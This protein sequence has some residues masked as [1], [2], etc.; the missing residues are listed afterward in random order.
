MRSQ[1]L[2]RKLN[3]QTGVYWS[4]LAL[5]FRFDG[6]LEQRIQ[7]WIERRFVDE[8]SAEILDRT[9]KQ[10]CGASS[11]WREL[12]PARWV[13]SPRN[14]SARAWVMPC[15]DPHRVQRNRLARRS[16]HRITPP[17]SPPEPLPLPDLWRS[18]PARRSCRVDPVWAEIASS[19]QIQL[20]P[21]E[22]IVSRDHGLT[23]YFRAIAWI[24]GASR[25]AVAAAAGA[26]STRAPVAPRTAE[27][28]GFATWASRSGLRRR[29]RQPEP[30]GA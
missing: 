20:I 25:L 19:V 27:A 21:L 18:A 14:R 8:R 7:C 30:E 26:R 24:T 29:L 28:S 1:I 22:I 16:A 11:S 3:L 4:L 13:R 15:A 17:S 9:P 6:R 10:R 12:I 23:R 2:P 5:A